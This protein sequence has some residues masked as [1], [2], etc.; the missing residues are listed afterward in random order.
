[1]AERIGAFERH[2]KGFGAK[3]LAKHGFAGRLGKRGQGIAAPIEVRVRARN[4]G[5]GIGG[6]VPKASSDTTSSRT[7]ARELRGVEGRSIDKPRDDSAAPTSAR[8]VL[9]RLEKDLRRLEICAVVESPRRSFRSPGLDKIKASATRAYGGLLACPERKAFGR[10]LSFNLEYLSKNIADV[11]AK[12]RAPQVELLR[13]ESTLHDAQSAAS[14]EK[15]RHACLLQLSRLASVCRPCTSEDALKLLIQQT[16][17]CGKQRTR[18]EVAGDLYTIVLPRLRQYLSAWN[19]IDNPEKLCSVATCLRNTLS[20]SAGFHDVYI[21]LLCDGLCERVKTALD[22]RNAKGQVLECVNMISALQAADLPKRVFQDH[23]EYV[24]ADKVVAKAKQCKDIESIH[25]WVLPWIAVLREHVRYILPRVKMLLESHLRSASTTVANADLSQLVDT[26]S[27]RRR[28][29]EHWGPPLIPILEISDL[30][31]GSIWPVW[32]A[33]MRHAAMCH[34]SVGR[35]AFREAMCWKHFA[36][37]VSIES[38][39]SNVFFSVWHSCL[40]RMLSSHRNRPFI[41]KAWFS[42]WKDVIE[43]YAGGAKWVSQHIDLALQI[44]AA[45]AAQPMQWVPCKYI[46]LSEAD[47]LRLLG[48]PANARHAPKSDISHLSITIQSA[49]AKAASASG[50]LFMPIYSDSVSGRL[51]KYGDV[52]VR[53][54]NYATY[55]RSSSSAVW[56]PCTLAHLIDQRVKST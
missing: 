47:K 53:V 4:A 22:S 8:K 36:V 21:Q 3:Y 18:S 12:Q 6:A 50:R 55:I 17:Q 35:S 30:V 41:A 24:I 14:S 33:C 54:D 2:T 38:D 26:L 25:A 45:W 48:A 10:E 46:L 23:I 7:S 28:V 49:L 43:T 1:M 42:G 9:S 5:L 40:Y 37:P 31:K 32:R 44:I 11:K 15:K 39:V 19:P 56:K 27:S 13:A 16:L 52:Y 34:P 20:F 29:L 51:Y